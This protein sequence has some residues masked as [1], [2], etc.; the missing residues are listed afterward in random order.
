[1]RHSR[2]A[3]GRRVPGDSSGSQHADLTRIGK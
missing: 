2:R 1:V 3:L